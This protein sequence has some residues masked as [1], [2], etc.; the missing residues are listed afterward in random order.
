MKTPIVK[1]HAVGGPEVLKLEEETLLAL[2]E[3]EARIRNIA[4]GVNYIDTYVRSG[5][6]PTQLPSP[7]GYEG[8][9]VVEAVGP[10]VTHLKPGDR[11]AYCQGPLGS[12]AAFRNMPA[13][14]V[15][16][17]PDALSFE[18]AAASMLKGLTVQYLF[19]QTYQLSKGETFLLHAAAGGVGLIACQYAKYLG[20]KLIGTVSSD[21]KA[22]LARSHGAWETINYK[23]ENILE[24]V[25]ELNGG[26]KLNVVYDSVGKDTWEASLNCLKPRGL[27]VSYGNA[28]G[29]VTG[30]NLGILA[31]KGSLYVTRPMLGAY[32]PTLKDMTEA[33]DKF[34]GL[35]VSGAIK[36]DEPQKFKM[37]DVTAA[38]KT[39]ESRERTG[40]LVLIP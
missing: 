33:A 24:R 26:Q 5:L 1:F 8:A 12:Y 25:L 7:L 36:I 31:Q 14:Q 18:V 29:A 32:V 11:V 17:I 30:V 16:K 15:V 9:G 19:T 6:Y 27:M 21:E 40:S 22:K 3:G 20:A 13:S 28:S 34:F 4:I 2:G 37:S 39:L 35:V 23:N 10:L 38:H